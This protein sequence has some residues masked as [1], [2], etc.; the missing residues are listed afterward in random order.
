SED[1]GWVAHFCVRAL[2]GQPLNV[3]G[4][5]RQVRDIL[6]IDDLL[7]AMLHAQRQPERLAGQAFN[8]GGGAGNTVSILELLALLRRRLGSLPSVSFH[9]W[10]TGDQ[11]YYVSDCRKL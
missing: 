10:R 2:Q 1:Q 7:D 6:H 5:G 4:D 8:V 9:P 3:Y 11:L